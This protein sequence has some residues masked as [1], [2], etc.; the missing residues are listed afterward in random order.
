MRATKGYADTPLGQVHYWRAGPKDGLPILLLHQTPWLGVQY[1]KVLPLL[2]AA[3]LNAIAVDTPGYGLSDLPDHQP[4]IEEY[5]DNLTHVLTALSLSKAA[6]AG[7]H[8]GASI[9]AAFAHRHPSHTRRWRR[10]AAGARP[11]VA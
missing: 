2:A 11:A 5:A 10:P 9:A 3:G 8:T 6:V 4:S 1:A 7:H